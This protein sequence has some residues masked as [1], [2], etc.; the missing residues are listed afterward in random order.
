MKK[1]VLLLLFMMFSCAIISAQKIQYSKG[2]IKIPGNGYLRLM[3]DVNG[4]HHLVHLPANGKPVISV[5]D[6]EL[7]LYAK[8]EID[9]KLNQDCDV[10]LVQ[11]K[12]YYLL[13]VHIKHSG[14]HQLIKIYNNGASA[15]ISSLFSNPTDSLWNRSFASF[16]LFNID[17]SLF[18]VTHSYFPQLKKIKTIIVKTDDIS[19]PAIL[20]RLL[21]DADLENEFLKEVTLYKNNLFIVKTGR[22]DDNKNILT[23]I[24]FNLTTGKLFTKQFESGQYVFLKPALRYRPADSGIFVY[25][26]LIPP[27]GYNAKS[28]GL[29]M[30]ALNDS[31]KEISPVSILTDVL[32]NNAAA[33]FIV[34][35]KLSSGWFGY[36]IKLNNHDFDLPIHIPINGV[37]NLTHTPILS[38]TPTV[39][40]GQ[41][42][43]SAVLLTVL[44]NKL[45]KVTDSLEK[46]N[47]SY[48]KI[49]PSPYAQFMMHKKVNLLLVQ[50][51]TKK[52]KALLL[53]SPDQNN[54][55]EMTTLRVYDRYNFALSLLQTTDNYFVVPFTDKKEM[56]LM[57]VTLN[58]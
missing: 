29:F 19:K 20:D 1:D 6:Q 36:T 38:N 46:N 30:V 23:I 8:T 11:F 58:N 12:D 40:Y 2:S 57:K 4:F 9:L 34:E 55:L 50:E 14:T 22:E 56:G 3:A 26:P 53:I 37:P 49:H 42:F 44:N 16:Q 28:S 15:D 54:E 48:Y 43:P 41:S 47:G 33:S 25:S 27:L 5:F 39:I 18:I 32:P 7:H 17:E 13:Y 31:L 10:S 35:K 24:K 21:F 52:R 51:L 45:D